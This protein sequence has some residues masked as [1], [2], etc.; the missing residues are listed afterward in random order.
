MNKVLIGLAIAVIIIVMFRMQKSTAVAPAGV[1]IGAAV[2]N[3]GAAPPNQVSMPAPSGSHGPVVQQPQTPADPLSPPV[4]TPSA[5]GHLQGYHLVADN[6]DYPG[7]DWMGGSF[8][9]AGIAS[10]EDCAAQCDA[11]AGCSAF[12]WEGPDSGRSPNVCWLKTGLGGSGYMQGMH[13]YQ[14]N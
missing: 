12:G 5:G 13:T 9:I 4:Q 3:P 1:A 6:A 8:S 2:S 11:G 14:K 7:N 10:A